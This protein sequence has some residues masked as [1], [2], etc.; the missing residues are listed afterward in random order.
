MIEYYF[1]LNKTKICKSDN[2][3]MTPSIKIAIA[4]RQKA[5]HIQYMG[6]ILNRTG[7]T[8]SS[9]KLK[10]Q[11]VSTLKNLLKNSMK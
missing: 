2:A 4:K 3:W 8:R 11:E 7:V 5:F 10:V 6:R 9:V 1:P